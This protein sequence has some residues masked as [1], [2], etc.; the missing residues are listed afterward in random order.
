ME[1]EEYNVLIKQVEEG[2]LSVGIRRDYARRLFTDV[3]IKNI[4]LKIGESLLVPKTIAMLT[5]CATP[6]FILVSWILAFYSY[7]WWGLIVVPPTFMGWLFYKSLS[8]RGGAG[9]KFITLLLFFVGY[10]HYFDVFYAKFFSAALFFYVLGLWFERFLYW[11]TT[12]ELRSLVL[13]NRKAIYEFREGI[14]FK[15]LI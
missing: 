8:V 10:I 11:Y 1:Q 9:L 5:F 15:E 6:L 12:R 13:R 3:P 2:K 14:V 7:G 4:N